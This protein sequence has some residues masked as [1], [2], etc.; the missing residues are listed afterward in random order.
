MEIC[1]F[2][3]MG[4]D[5]SGI[6]STIWMFQIDCK[7][8]LVICLFWVVEVSPIPPLP[9]AVC[10]MY[11]KKLDLWKP[12]V[13]TS[14]Y[15]LTRRSLKVKSQ[16]ERVNIDASYRLVN[17]EE[18]IS[19]SGRAPISHFQFA[20][21]ARKN[22]ASSTSKAPSSKNKIYRLPAKCK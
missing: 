17:K 14:S 19:T 3:D 10:L 15:S 8:N 18:I 4:R 21:R 12:H 20:R 22:K 1:C 5:Q 16:P 6:N 7:L 11:R 9:L 13:A 2:V